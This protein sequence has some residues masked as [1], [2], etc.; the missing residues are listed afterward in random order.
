MELVCILREY[1]IGKLDACMQTQFK[2]CSGY[3]LF[4]IYRYLQDL[5]FNAKKV[6]ITGRLHNMDKRSHI[7]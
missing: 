3:V 1:C 7:K 2:V 5:R 6:E 4:S